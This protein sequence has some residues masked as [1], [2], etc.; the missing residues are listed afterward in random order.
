VE[1][2]IIKDCARNGIQVTPS[3]SEESV[4]GIINNLIYQCENDG[5]IYGNSGTT[6]K[7]SGHAYNNTVVDCYRGIVLYKAPSDE[8]SSLIG[9]N[10]ICQN[11]IDADYVNYYPLHRNFYLHNCISLDKS[12]QS[13][14][15]YGKY[16]LQENIS[17]DSMAEFYEN[18]LN[19]GEVYIEF[20]SRALE[21]FDLDTTV[22]YPA[23][24]NALTLLYDVTFPFST[25]I[26]NR[27]RVDT[28]WDIGAFEI[29]DI[30]A[31][32]TDLITGPVTIDAL[33][34][35]SSDTIGLVLYL[36][37]DIRTDIDANIQF[38][39]I[40]LLNAY[41]AST[42]GQDSFNLTIYVQ[43]GTSHEGTFDL[44]DRGV[45]TVDISSDPDE[46]SLGIPTLVSPSS[47]QLIDDTAIQSGITFTGLK[48]VNVNIN[49]G[50]IGT[51]E[52]LLVSSITETTDITIVNSIVEIDG[53][54]LIRDADRCDVHVLN[55]IVIY[56]N[57]DDESTL[58][59]T[60]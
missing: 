45:R 13:G 49:E 42:L 48:L 26:V 39:S 21:H 54:R 32:D 57:S 46:Y 44:T 14:S 43:G 2:N 59:L 16:Y 58:Y 33:G 56:R 12:S 15:Q 23:I 17:I 41:I 51:I 53:N 9:K 25:D 40:A 22:D 20:I 27:D 35:Y 18:A 24:N 38:T 1:S 30:E 29:T 36:R 52:D 34:I 31:G 55:S 4:D 37:D 3:T 6:N 19:Q 5:I 8:S 28:F 11:P 60:A 7:V 10:N 50:V 47:S